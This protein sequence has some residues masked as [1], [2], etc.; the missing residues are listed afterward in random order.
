MSQELHKTVLLDA[1]VEALI[2]APSG[3]YIDGTF[4]R[5]GHSRQILSLLSDTGHLLGLDKDAEAIAFAESLSSEN[6][7]FSYAQGSFADLVSILKTRQISGVNGVL[8]DLGV[9][10]PQLDDATRGFSF[11]N[12]GPLDMRMDVSRGMS[13]ADWV[14][15]ASEAEIADTL[16][17][18]G[19]EKFFRRMARAVV[20]ARKKQAILTTR[21]LAT[22]VAEA[23]PAWEKGKHPATRAF[24][25]IR[26][27]INNELEDLELGLEAAVD[28]LLPGGRLV[29]ISFHSLEDRI[30]KRFMRG[31]VKGPE[32]PRG[33]PVQERDLVREYALVGKAVKPNEAEVEQNVRARSA[34]MRV[35]EKVQL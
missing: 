1:A 12:D 28:S 29:V 9:S 27:K 21:Q 18:Y 34:V 30:V 8:L 10:S 35:L 6:K 2:T 25:A 19:E 5:G 14:A 11:M 23:N 15:S 32:L 16:K 33:I 4:G 31:K 26:I 24:Q 7:C 17:V 3:I 20:E 22:I 13:A